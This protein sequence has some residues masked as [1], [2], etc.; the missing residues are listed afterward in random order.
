MEQPEEI[1]IRIAADG[2]VYFDG[3]SREMLEIAA[4]LCP[5]DPALAKRL[6]A[7]KRELSQSTPPI[8]VHG[9]KE[10]LHGHAASDQ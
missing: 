2:R 5:G 10:Q 1:N 4:D 7:V 9:D 6:Q 8:N 3:L